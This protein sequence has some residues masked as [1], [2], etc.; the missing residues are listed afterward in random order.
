MITWFTTPAWSTCWWVSVAWNTKTKQAWLYICF[1]N[2]WQIHWPTLVFKVTD[3]FSALKVSSCVTSVSKHLKSDLM[4]LQ[5]GDSTTVRAQIEAVIEFHT[6]YLSR[7]SNNI[8][9]NQIKHHF[10]GDIFNVSN[11]LHRMH[12]LGEVHWVLVLLTSSAQVGPVKPI[13][14]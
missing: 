1:S 14:Q 2:R 10:R 3:W 13:L 11:T 7:R 4:F 9:W 6:G 5:R 12:T 8:T